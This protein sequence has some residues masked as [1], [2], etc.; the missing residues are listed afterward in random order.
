MP[1]VHA[2]QLAAGL[3]PQDRQDLAAV[4]PVLQ[5]ARETRGAGWAERQGVGDGG[6]EV[7]TCTVQDTGD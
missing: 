6:E 5:A 4:R 7:H 2:D 1:R 3:D